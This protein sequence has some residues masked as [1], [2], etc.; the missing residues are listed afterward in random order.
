GYGYS[1]EHLVQAL[2]KQGTW[3]ITGTTRDAEKRG[4]M[5]AQGLKSYLFNHDR[6]LGDPQ[7]FLEGVTHL[8]ISIP[9]NDEGA[10]T[11]NLHAQDILDMPSLEWVGYLSSTNVYG[12]RGGA[13]VDEDTEPYPSSTRGSRRAFAEAQWMSLCMNQGLPVH[14]FRPA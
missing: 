13:W 14:I 1:C 10:P 6:P 9:P 4:A 2:Q 11:F 7:V 3:T 5:R 8:L 12:D